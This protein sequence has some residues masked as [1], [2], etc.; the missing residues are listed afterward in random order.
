MA[1]NN[2]PFS[3]IRDRLVSGVDSYKCDLVVL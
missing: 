1:A 3:S 2:A